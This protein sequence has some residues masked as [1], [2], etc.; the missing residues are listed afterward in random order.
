MGEAP[1]GRGQLSA[2][3][4]RAIE[5]DTARLDNTSPYPVDGGH[6]FSSVAAGF[7]TTIGFLAGQPSP[8]PAGSPAAAAPAATPAA[9]AATAAPD[10]SAPPAPSNDTSSSSAATGAIV[11][12]AVGGAGECQA[13]GWVEVVLELAASTAVASCGRGGQP[14]R[15]CHPFVLLAHPAAALAC[16][17]LAVGW[18]RGWW[19]GRRPAAAGTGRSNGLQSAKLAPAQPPPASEQSLLRPAAGAAGTTALPLSYVSSAEG[20][21]TSAS[22]GPVPTHR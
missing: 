3:D 15:T 4:T 8:A 22:G 11:G 1:L 20:A 7:G 10:G 12:G 2:L 17:V 5:L 9:V 13:V 18:H 19:P 21:R 14:I 16:V 6:N